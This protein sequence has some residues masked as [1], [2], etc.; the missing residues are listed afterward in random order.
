MFMVIVSSMSRHRPRQLLAAG[1]LVVGC[2]TYDSSLLSGALN[3]QV[4]A[5]TAGAP[6]LPDEDAGAGSL[7]EGGAPMDPSS[8]GALS[9]CAFYAYCPHKIPVCAEQ[10]PPLSEISPGEKVACFLYAQKHTV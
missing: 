4:I 7:A 1:L 5:G 6:A 3:G 10:V 9:G 8:A 2:N